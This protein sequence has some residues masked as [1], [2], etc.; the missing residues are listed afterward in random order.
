M[1]TI[2]NVL[3]E[4]NLYFALIILGASVFAVI[5]LSLPE[6]SVYWDP[7]TFGLL[8]WI[9]AVMHFVPSLPSPDAEAEQRS[10]QH[11]ADSE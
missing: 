11:R 5:A 3:G 7:L 1:K 9:L 4:R 2:R 8:I 6:D 10:K